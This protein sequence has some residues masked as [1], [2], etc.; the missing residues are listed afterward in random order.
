MT[1][2]FPVLRDDQSPNKA[3]LLQLY[4]VL[5]FSGNFRR[6]VTETIQMRET[7]FELLAWDEKVFKLSLLNFGSL[8]PPT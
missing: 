1:F 8:P 4:S 2:L 3:I 6:T 7:A 5:R